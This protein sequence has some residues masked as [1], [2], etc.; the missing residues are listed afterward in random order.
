MFLADFFNRIYNEKEIFVIGCKTKKWQKFE[1]IKKIVLLPGNITNGV[2][3]MLLIYL[4]T[5]IKLFLYA[6][7]S[8]LSFN[9]NVN[10]SSLL[11]YSRLK[12]PYQTIVLKRR[13]TFRMHSHF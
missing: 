3:I 2:T 13:V 6:G 5:T 7:A 9:W 8:S 11:K 10:V 12:Y 1:F 4:S